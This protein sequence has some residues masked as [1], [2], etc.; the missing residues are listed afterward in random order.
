VAF[1]PFTLVE[2]GEMTIGALMS[3]LAI[4]QQLVGVCL[5]LVAVFYLSRTT[6]NSVSSATQAAPLLCVDVKSQTTPG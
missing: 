6:S 2:R 1:Y 5:I 4:L 3:S